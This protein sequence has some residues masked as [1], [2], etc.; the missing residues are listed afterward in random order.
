MNGT[1]I[2]RNEKP[3]LLTLEDSE[4]SATLFNSPGQELIRNLGELLWESE[5]LDEEPTFGIPQI[6]VAEEISVQNI[7]ELIWEY[8]TEAAETTAV[9]DL[10]LMKIQRR[11]YRNGCMNQQL[12]TEASIP[13]LSPA[14]EDVIT[15]LSELSF[16]YDV[17]N[18][19]LTPAH[20]FRN[21]PQ[22]TKLGISLW[23]I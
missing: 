19:E 23:R 18:N 7:G 1:K 9:P 20:A 13:L 11:I 17:R 16:E 21:F 22:G 6:S 14:E 15:N 2:A 5:D 3:K 8:Q 4:T 12:K 10:L